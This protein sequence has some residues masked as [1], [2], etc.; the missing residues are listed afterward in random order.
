MKCRL[1]EMFLSGFLHHLQHEDKEGG[2]LPEMC[3][4]QTGLQDLN[5]SI[6]WIRASMSQFLFQRRP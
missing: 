2:V 4:K 3:F 5:L 1:A 6:S